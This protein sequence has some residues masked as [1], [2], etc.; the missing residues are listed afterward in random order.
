[1]VD[2]HAEPVARSAEPARPAAVA[3]AGASAAV[4]ASAIAH[5]STTRKTDFFWQHTGATWHLLLYLVLA[6]ALAWLAARRYGPAPAGVAG[7]VARACRIGAVLVL[8]AMLA[9]PAWRT[10]ETTVVPGSAL[11]AIDRSA[12]MQRQDAPGDRPRIAL[13]GD[14]RRVLAPLAESRDLQLDWQSVGGVAGPLLD[15]DF[16]DAQ[17][18][19]NGSASPL[20]EELVR[21]L[22]AKHYDLLVLLSD[23]RVTA[24]PGL[25]T[26]ATHLRSN[27]TDLA[28][29]PVGGE[30][31]DARI[32]IDQIDQIQVNPMAALGERE[33]VTVRASVRGLAPG[34]VTVRVWVDGA[35]ADEIQAE[36]PAG[37]PS[38]LHAF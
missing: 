33:P 3:D 34:P 12:S 37:D 19:A 23:G 26:L 27:G 25:D 1:M 4:G 21:L 36:A 9:G 18:T 5:A 13:A 11:V 29:L 10:T 38:A 15:A 7:R 22:D 28:V 30:G 24:G 14:L 16:A 35:K 2:S 20:A 8:V 6:I 17:P 31:I 32:L